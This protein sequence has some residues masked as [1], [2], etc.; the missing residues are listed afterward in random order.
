M[1]SCTDHRYVLGSRRGSL[2]VQL[3]G[4]ADV[5]ARS[6]VLA[7]ARLKSNRKFSVSARAGTGLYRA[8]VRR[9]TTVVSTTLDRNVPG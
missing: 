6:R 4:R 9:G 1:C 3:V 8:V 5:C 7:T 2:T